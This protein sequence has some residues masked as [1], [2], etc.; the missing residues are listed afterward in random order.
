MDQ[1]KNNISVDPADTA[2]KSAAKADVKNAAPKK[3]PK[4]SVKEK[5]TK[6]LREYRSELKKIVWYSREQT[7]KS[8]VI[9]IIS[10]VIVGAFIGGLDYFF[11]SLLMWLGKLI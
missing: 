1:D 5:V 7:F 11:S 10:V 3:K 6:A 2:E 8:S 9:V 4:I